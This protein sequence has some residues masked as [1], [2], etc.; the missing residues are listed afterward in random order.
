[1]QES[2]MNETDQRAVAAKGDETALEDL[3]RDCTSFILRTA[4]KTT[5]TYVDQSDDRWSIS[6]AA[7]YE[8]VRAF[9]PGKGGFLS[10]AATVIRRR[11]QDQWKRERAHSA[12][13]TTDP[14]SFWDIPDRRD[15][16]PPD[17]HWEIQAMQA[18]LAHYDADFFEV[19]RSSPKA[20]KTKAACARIIR[21]LADRPLA[22]ADLWRTR[23]LPIALLAKE[24]ALPR[25]IMERHRTY[26]IAAVEILGGDF[27][28]LQE[29]FRHMRT[30]G[31]GER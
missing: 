1:M 18:V 20:E 16:Q 2:A 25:K 30:K 5:G 22:A 27:P 28:I 31:D 4:Y 29:Y 24:L 11:L 21:F 15:G 26:I 7:F 17:I 8:A 13:T 14:A 6:L 12:E 10:F 23:R 3:I 19:A 9:E